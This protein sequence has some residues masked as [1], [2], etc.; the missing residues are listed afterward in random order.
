[1]KL[2][3]RD[4]LRISAGVFGLLAVLSLV[5]AGTG[6]GHT[7]RDLNAY[8]TLAGFRGLMILQA[9]LA[10][11]SG[12]GLLLR[13]RWGFYLALCTSLFLFTVGFTQIANGFPTALLA[14]PGGIALW[15]CVIRTRTLFGGPAAMI[16][17]GTTET[18]PRDHS[19][20]HAGFGP[21]LDATP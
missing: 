13:Q 16:P 8:Y 12:V 19:E 9:V 2:L 15:W 5:L 18:W 4:F 1:M 10:I 6:W 14:V 20:L 21:Q 17:H 11:A 3:P 7:S